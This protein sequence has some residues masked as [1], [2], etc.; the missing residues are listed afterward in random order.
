MSEQLLPTLSTGTRLH[1]VGEASSLGFV[2]PTHLEKTSALTLVDYIENLT[3]YPGGI[4]DH[5]MEIYSHQVKVYQKQG[6]GHGQARILANV[7]VTSVLETYGDHLANARSSYR[8]LSGIWYALD[9]TPNP[10]LTLQTV[11]EDRAMD[12]RDAAPLVRYA[13]Q[14]RF[15][16]DQESWQ[17][18]FDP[19]VSIENRK[20]PRKGAKKRIEDVY[21]GENDRRVD[22]RIAEFL[23][24]TTVGGL[25]KS[26]LVELAK[27]DQVRR[28]KF[29]VRVLKGAR[30]TYR[31]HAQEIIDNAYIYPRI[32]QSNA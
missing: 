22:D 26:T 8:L 20:N 32:A 13:D 5:L 23:G 7:S 14:C 11:F 19:F 28:G 10:K 21:T 6:R 2:P 1:S 12:D 3:R 29:W 18:D 15:I 27:G 24:C 25:Y 30:G 4:H 16:R 17:Y 31:S 9:S